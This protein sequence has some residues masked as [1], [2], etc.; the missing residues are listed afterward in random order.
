MA[1]DFSTLEH[2]DL[3]WSNIYLQAFELLVDRITGYS[4]SH[5]PLKTLDISGTHFA[6]MAHPT[7]MDALLEDLQIKAPRVTIIQDT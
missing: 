1:I 6:Q 4:T 7:T 5:L 3:R 2:L